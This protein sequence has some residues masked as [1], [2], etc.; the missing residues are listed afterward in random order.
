VTILGRHKADRA[1]EMLRVVPGDEVFDPL[2]GGLDDIAV[3]VAGLTAVAVW[4]TLCGS[5]PIIIRG[6]SLGLIENHGRHADFE[7]RTRESRL[8]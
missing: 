4:L 3:F 6:S 5:I 1:V 7:T 8:C 2:A